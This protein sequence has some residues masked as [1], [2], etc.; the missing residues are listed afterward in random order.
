MFKTSGTTGNPL[1]IPYEE[2]FY[3]KTLFLSVRKIALISGYYI[4]N[5]SHIYNISLTD[6]PN[7]SNELWL[8]PENLVGDMLQVFI[9]ISD[10][11]ECVNVINQ[12]NK[13]DFES[14]SL[15]P[16]ILKL[17]VNIHLQKNIK[18]KAK[19]VICSGANLSENL[20][21][22]AKNVLKIPVIEAYGLTEVGIVASNCACNKGM[23]IY[24]DLKVDVKNE[25]K[26][27]GHDKNKKEGNLLLTSMRN[28]HL[29]LINYQTNDIVK[30]KLS[31]CSCF[32]DAKWRIVELKG[33]IMQ[34]FVLPSGKYFPAS[35]FHNL[36]ALIRMR[37]F[38]VIQR[39]IGEFLF[40]V[41]MRV[42]S[43][44]NEQMIREILKKIIM[45]ECKIE[46]TFKKINYTQTKFQRFISYL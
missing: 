24:D 14:L 41:D 9:D 8:S 33:R 32:H 4:G 5:K 39:K 12:L 23:V 22:L 26:F 31:N 29:P 38:Q 28:K 16:E 6:N 21:E 1:K 2:K 20:K 13:L 45:E 37:E 17:L 19:Y 36:F 25:K 27:A 42:D 18:P 44:K 46:V 11:S 43:E 7:C 40:I 10:I 35:A 3:L 30:L 15:K 34:N